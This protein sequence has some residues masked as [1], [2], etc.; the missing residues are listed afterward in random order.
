MGDY[1]SIDPIAAQLEVRPS[2]CSTFAQ[3]TLWG[4]AYVKSYETPSERAAR[5]QRERSS[6]GGGRSSRGGGGGH[7]GGGGSGIR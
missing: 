1:T 3:S 5:I 7:S 6:G 4:M 2:F